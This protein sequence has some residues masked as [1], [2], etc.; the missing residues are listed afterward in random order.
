MI[1][2]IKIH[3]DKEVW[4]ETGYRLVTIQLIIDDLQEI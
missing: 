2:D 4:E 3:E 1:T